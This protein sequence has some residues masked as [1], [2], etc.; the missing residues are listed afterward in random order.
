MTV[1]FKAC[2]AQC[3]SMLKKFFF[4]FCQNL[5]LVPQI[6]DK[7]LSRSLIEKNYSCRLTGPAAPSITLCLLWPLSMSQKTKVQEREVWVISQQSYES[8]IWRL[9]CYGFVLSFFSKEGWVITPE[10]LD[11]WFRHDVMCGIVEQFS[12]PIRK[13]R[14]ES[15]RAGQRTIISQAACVPTLNVT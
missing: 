7:V 5:L 8:W 2:T 3:K 4:P 14:K 15:E 9:V 10:E 12:M 11:T 13:E 6:E 1:S